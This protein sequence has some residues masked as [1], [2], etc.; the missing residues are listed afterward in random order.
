M[1]VLS[2]HLGSIMVVIDVDPQRHP[3]TPLSG[4]VASAAGSV[5]LLS[6]C[7]E[8][9]VVLKCVTQASFLASGVEMVASPCQGPLHSRYDAYTSQSCDMPSCTTPFF[10]K[11]LQLSHVRSE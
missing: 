2:G 7:F 11:A 6:W 3:H 8:H 4:D 10:N 1:I 5:Q 9:S